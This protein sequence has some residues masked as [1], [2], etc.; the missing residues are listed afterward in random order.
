MND[1]VIEADARAGTALFRELEP[2]LAAVMTARGM[3]GG[4]AR[5]VALGFLSAF[6]GYLARGAGLNAAQELYAQARKILKRA[7]H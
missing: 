4:N 1:E 5:D 2:R 7:A 3:A 6:G